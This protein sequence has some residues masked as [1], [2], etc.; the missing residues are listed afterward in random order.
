MSLLFNKKY[1]TI[2]TDILYSYRAVKKKSFVKLNTTAKS[3]DI[4]INMLSQACKKKMNV[5]E[6]PSREKSRVF[7]YSK[8]NTFKGVE[9]IFQILLGK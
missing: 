7:G 3:F 1:K 5:M 4:E 8:L 9:F 2:F 6:M